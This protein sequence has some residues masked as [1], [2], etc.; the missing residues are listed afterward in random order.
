MRRP[1]LRAVAIAG[2]VAAVPALTGMTPA[3]AAAQPSWKLVTEFGTS[4]GSPELNGGVAASAKSAWVVGNTYQ[5]EN[6][7]FLAHWNG[8]R[9]SQVAGP[10]ALRS[11]SASVSP[12]P[13]AMSGAALWAF[14][15]QYASTTKVYAARLSGGHWTLWRLRGAMR[16]DGAAVFGNSDVWAFGEALLPKGWT[17]LENGPAFAEHFDGKRWRR[18]SLPGVPLIVR[19][20]SRT[21][22][23]AYG[24]T[25]R[26]ASAEN[27]SFVA[28]H[29]NGAKWRTL[30]IPRIRAT[31][32]KLMWPAGFTVL[33]HDSLWATEDFHC[34]HPGVCSPAQPAG[35]IL[36]HWNGHRW[37]RVLDSSAYEVPAVESD[38]RG[39]LWIE[40][41][42]AKHSRWA[43]LHYIRGKVSVSFVPAAAGGSPV[44]VSEPVPVPG[45][46]R[47]WSTADVQVGGGQTVA[48][49][50]KYGP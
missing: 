45:T 18:V 35:I 46:T 13:I 2:L 1:F 31:N 25:N 38:G 7:L 16:I 29:W 27:Q 40:A 33:K 4:Y 11:T 15:S 41:L 34:P 5:T 36:A 39:G 3:A 32:G 21:D 6:S 47:P 14:P 44:N 23:W 20:L 26:T 28:M 30:A 43:Y 24:P 49:V 9:W 17:G 8:T 10:S 22:I 42:T 37:V 12:G 50:F 19:A 48:A